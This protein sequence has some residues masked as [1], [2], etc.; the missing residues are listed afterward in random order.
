MTSRDRNSLINLQNSNRQRHRHT[1]F[2]TACKYNNGITH[3]RKQILYSKYLGW[4]WVNEYIF[5]HTFI[6]FHKTRWFTVVTW[7]LQISLLTVH[8]SPEV[9]KKNR[10]TEQRHH[11]IGRGRKRRSCRGTTKGAQPDKPP[12]RSGDSVL[13]EFP[14]SKGLRQSPG[15]KQ[16]LLYMQVYK[17]CCPAGPS[18]LYIMVRLAWAVVYT[19]LFVLFFIL[20]NVCSI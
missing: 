9:P 11:L 12:G 7:P 6:S 18:H 4:Y 19:A 8:P 5:K 14:G 15:A 17:H 3:H 2:K 20:T 16:R 13:H 1:N 10:A